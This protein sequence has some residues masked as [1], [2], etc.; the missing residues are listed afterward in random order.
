MKSYEEIHQTFQNQLINL[1]DKLEKIITA[2]W[3]MIDLKEA[4]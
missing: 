1:G 3:K 4:D 2:T